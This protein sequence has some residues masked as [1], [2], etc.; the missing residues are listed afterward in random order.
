MR[1]VAAFVQDPYASGAVEELGKSGIAACVAYT[2]RE[3]VDVGF[4]RALPP[5]LNFRDAR[6]ESDWCTRAHIADDRTAAAM[7]GNGPDA[8][9]F[10]ILGPLGASDVPTSSH[11]STRRV[12]I[13]P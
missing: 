6:D 12:S 5:V 13:C 8:Q 10:G 7:Q 2:L 4:F 1:T 3:S 11:S 9:T